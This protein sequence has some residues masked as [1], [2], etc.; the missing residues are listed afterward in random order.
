MKVLVMAGDGAEALETL[1]PIQ[2]LKEEGFEVHVAAPRKKVLQTVVHDFE[3]HME[4]YTEKLGYRVQADLSF[5]EVNPADYDALYIVGGRAPEWIRNEPG[6]LEIV[7]HFFEN[8]KPVGT[9]CHGPL[10]LLAAGV[11]KGRKLAAYWALKPDIELAG[12]TFV[13]QEAV[14][15]GNLVTARAW[16]DHPAML[17][18]FVR[19]LKQVSA[20]VA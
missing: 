11:V 14:V 18:E 7:R 13:D 16:I 20:R 6:A 15:D 17:R 3:P 9:L 5:K 4:T 2:R 1:Y 8:N 10:V 12:G 19:L